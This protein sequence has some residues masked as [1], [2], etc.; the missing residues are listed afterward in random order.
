MAPQAGGL[1]SVFEAFLCFTVPAASGFAAVICKAI[2]WLVVPYTTIVM[3]IIENTH[4]YIPKPAKQAQVEARQELQRIAATPDLL[5]QDRG[6]RVTI[7]IGGVATWWSQGLSPDTPVFIQHAIGTVKRIHLIDPAT[8]AVGVYDRMAKE[9]WERRA[10][11][12]RPEEILA[13]LPAKALSERAAGQ[14]ASAR[15]IAVVSKLLEIPADQPVPRLSAIAAGRLLDRIVT[16]KVVIVLSADFR[17]FLALP[18]TA[19]A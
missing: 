5:Q 4:P 6:A 9:T 3:H 13:S 16:E 1:I 7:T 18:R 2:H 17:N 12:E 11:L 10:I 8:L 15:Q 19:A 14:P